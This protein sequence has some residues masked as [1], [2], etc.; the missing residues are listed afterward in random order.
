MLDI[1]SS[2]NIKDNIL[3]NDSSLIPRG[4]LPDKSLFMDIANY[5]QLLAY[6]HSQKFDS[7]IL[8]NKSNMGAGVLMQFIDLEGI[9]TVSDMAKKLKSLPNKT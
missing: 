9:D 3:R 6:K 5:I 8:F 2:D 1:I 4:K 7:I